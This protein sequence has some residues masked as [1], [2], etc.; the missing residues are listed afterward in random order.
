VKLADVDLPAGPG[1]VTL[2]AI[3]CSDCE[4]AELAF[5]PR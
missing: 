5:T 4:V 2:R 3:D 1:A